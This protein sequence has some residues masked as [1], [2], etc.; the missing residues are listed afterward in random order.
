MKTLACPDTYGTNPV[1]KARRGVWFA[2]LATTALVALAPAPAHAAFAIPVVA[3]AAGSAITANAAALS[4]TALTASILAT[5]LNVVAG[6][7]TFLLQSRGSS[8]RAQRDSRSR[9]FDPHPN[10]RF[11]FGEFPQ[12]GSVVFHHSVGQAYYLVV[13][14]NSL[15]SEA[16]TRI[17]INDGVHLEFADMTALT[18]FSS[19]HNPTIAVYADQAGT[20]DAAVNVHIGLGDQTAPPERW[21]SEIGP[22]GQFSDGTI[23]ATDA[24]QG[25]T[26]AFIRFI[27]GGEEKAA[28]RWAQGKPPPMRFFGQWSKVYDPRLDSSSGVTGAS[29]SH[30][31]DDPSTWAYSENAALCALTLVRHRYALGFSDERIPIQQWA[32][33]ADACEGGPEV[34]VQNTIVSNVNGGVSDA[35]GVSAGITYSGFSPTDIVTASLVPGIGEGAWSPW[36]APALS[37]P[38]TGALTRF[39]IAPDGNPGQAV[40]VGGLA[41]RD[42]YANAAADFVPGAVSGGSSYVV[43][44]VDTPVSDNTGSFGVA[45]STGGGGFRCD[46]LVV[47]EEREISLLDPVLACF[48]GQL[49]TTDGLLGVRAGVWT[50]PTITL[51]EPVGDELEIIG[52]RDEGYDR[53]R[54]KYIS[55]E[56]EYEETD[57]TGYAIRDGFRERPLQLGLVREPVQAERLAKIAALTGSPRRSIT[58]TWDGREAQRRIG[59]RVNFSLVGF[60]RAASTYRITGKHFFFAEQDDGLRLEVQ[61]TLVEDLA[62]FYAFSGADYTPPAPYS[63]PEQSIPGIEAPTGCE[64]TVEEQAEQFTEGETSLYIRHRFLP[65]EGVDWYRVEVYE[66]EYGDSLGDRTVN[67]QVDA[68]QTIDDAGTT[69][70]EHVFGRVVAGVE[71]RFRAY[72]RSA[73]LG[74]SETPLECTILAAPPSDVLGLPQIVSQDHDGANTATHRLRAPNAPGVTALRLAAGDQADRSDLAIIATVNIGALGEHDF[75]DVNAFSARR[76]LRAVAIDQFGR[77]G[78]AL[79]FDYLAGSSVENFRAREGGGIRLREGGGFRELE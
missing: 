2:Y 37:G 75:L 6:V 67:V 35:A 63:P 11:A 72:A 41:P 54:P 29:G 49:D 42:G 44:I 9:A 70:V 10:F 23:A 46:G 53:V 64:L 51:T 12:E 26:V 31:P 45:L 73:D 68:S 15:P 14:L 43:Y 74:L 7:A 1:R 62:S 52:A 50:A 78:Q 56:R 8:S 17:E 20:R 32:D 57:G 33:A 34:V 21:L 47:I 60:P 27:H 5:A 36:G 79:D 3:A 25:H 76:Y 16:V 22:G 28:R 66:E 69:K 39:S 58:G 71:Y 77:E 18:D 38:Q 30:L 48:A 61:L 65:V 13:L 4:L 55:R 24:W 59:E 19:D 40:E